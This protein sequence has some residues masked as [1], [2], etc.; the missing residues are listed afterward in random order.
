MF[1][2]VAYR[3]FAKEIKM[4]NGKLLR[5]TSRDNREVFA[6]FKKGGPM[7]GATFGEKFS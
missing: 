1:V 5:K 4:N 3:M 6:V 7:E 2:N